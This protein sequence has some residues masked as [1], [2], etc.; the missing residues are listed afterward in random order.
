MKKI[1]LTIVLLSVPL[2]AQNWTFLQESG[3]PQATYT[4]GDFMTTDISFALNQD[5]GPYTVEF[6]IG[7][8]NNDGTGWT[9]YAASWS[10]QDGNNRYW[11]FTDDATVQ[12]NSTGKWYYAARFVGGTT[13]YADGGWEENNVVLNTVAYFQVNGAV[14]VELTTFTASA[15]DGSVVLNWET[16]TEVNNYGFDV[17]ASNDKENWDV[18]GFVEGHGNSNSPNS[19]SFVATDNSQYYRLKQVDIDGGF[20][21]SDVVEVA[22]NLSY[23]LAQNH[24]NP[25]NP[26]TQISFSLPEASKVQVTVYNALGQEVAELANREFAAGNHSVNFNAAGL[27]SG[28]YFYK[29]SS[30][31]FTETKKMM[32]VK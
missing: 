5:T 8:A 24:P 23:K 25:F 17:E 2:L 19:Y 21:Y 11:T 3:A 10:H 15:V 18:V 28:L 14:P 4:E 6:G 16:A 27:S 12:F 1:F 30:A 22:S 20:E 26:T 32:L 13:Y 31:N 7:P 29:L 9:W